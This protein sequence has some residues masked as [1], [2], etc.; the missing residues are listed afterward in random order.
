[1]FLQLSLSL[2]KFKVQ[3]KKEGKHRDSPD[4]S[5]AHGHNL[6]SACQRGPCVTTGGLVLAHQDPKFMLLLYILCV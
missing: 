6:P 4:T 1:M 3:S 5:F 2:V